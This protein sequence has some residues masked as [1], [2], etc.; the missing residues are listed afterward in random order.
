MACRHSDSMCPKLNSSHPLVYPPPSASDLPLGKICI[1]SLGLCHLHLPK[2]KLWLSVKTSL[3]HSSP[4]SR[5]S[6]SP[7]SFTLKYF[8]NLSYFLFTLPLVLVFIISHHFHDLPVSRFASFQ[9]I[10]SIADIT[11]LLKSDQWPPCPAEHCSNSQAVKE[12]L[13]SL[14]PAFPLTIPSLPFT[15]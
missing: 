12:A 11:L 1:F 6:P 9:A 13:S 4:I 14:A 15:L 3:S 7:V 2:L 5:E 10:F 8:S